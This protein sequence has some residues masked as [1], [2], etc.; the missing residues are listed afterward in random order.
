MNLFLGLFQISKMDAVVPK[1]L[2]F[3]RKNL[4]MVC[5]PCRFSLSRESVLAPDSFQ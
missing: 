2:V 3:V 5:F 1:F 4:M